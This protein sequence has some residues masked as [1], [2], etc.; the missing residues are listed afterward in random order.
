[1]VVNLRRNFSCWPAL[2]GAV[3]MLISRL[4]PTSS[5]LETADVNADGYA[6]ITTV[7][8]REGGSALICVIDIMLGVLP[9]LC[10]MRSWEG[11]YLLF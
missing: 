6:I 10:N 1:M 4:T 2:S 7:I 8:A 11:L 9:C 5:D 3:G